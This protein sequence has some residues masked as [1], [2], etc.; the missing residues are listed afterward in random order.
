MSE[1]RKQRT[2][3]RAEPRFNHSPAAA[4]WSGI[5]SSYRASGT[6][7]RAPTS[8]EPE[9]TS[10]QHGDVHYAVQ[11]PDYPLSVVSPGSSTVPFYEAEIPNQITRLPDGQREAVITRQPLERDLAN[12]SARL[13]RLEEG[14]GG[15]MAM[16][17]DSPPPTQPDSEASSRYGTAAGSPEPPTV[18]SEQETPWREFMF[19]SVRSPGMES[20]LNENR[21][22]RDAGQGLPE[23]YAEGAP[24]PV[25][26]AAQ[27]SPWG[28]S[29]GPSKP[30]PPKPTRRESAGSTVEIV[31]SPWPARYP[32]FPALRGPQPQMAVIGTG[33]I[34]HCLMCERPLDNLHFP[35]YVALP[36]YHRSRRYAPS[37]SNPGGPHGVVFWSREYSTN[38]TNTI[39]E[40]PSWGSCAKCG[41]AFHRQCVEV[42]LRNME[43]NREQPKCI[44]LSC[45]DAWPHPRRM[46]RN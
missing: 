41:S 1:Q 20:R 12:L 4:R 30:A 36:G 6:R 11:L 16:E 43:A 40:E 10:P 39:R 23:D 26:E 38:S 44:N 7:D 18:A 46:Y 34:G 37:Y 24:L 2:A 22:S 27:S 42:Y 8:D 25:P 17:P 5:Q 3:S 9:K 13:R 32:R 33:G 35:P 14:Y 45:K 29:P 28:K 15:L 31:R 19:G 21:L